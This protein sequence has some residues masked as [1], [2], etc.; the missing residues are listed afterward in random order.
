M[1]NTY[2]KL[3][4]DMDLKKIFFY[5]ILINGRKTICK[6]LMLNWKSI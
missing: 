4:I 3:E 5:P 2:G 1:Q 6:T